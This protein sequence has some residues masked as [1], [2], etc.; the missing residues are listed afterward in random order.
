VSGNNEL[1]ALDF[2]CVKVLPREFYNPYFELTKMEN[3]K[4]PKKLLPLL[5]ELEMVLEED[6]IADKKL[7]TDT[8]KDIL[9]ILNQPFQFDV[10]DFSQPEFF[11]DL[12]KL[13]STLKDDKRIRKL[14]GNRGSK[15]FLYVN[16]T[17]F[18]LLG[19]MNSLKAGPIKVMNYKKYEL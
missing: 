13:G 5:D 7:L 14:N 11:N 18:G 8:F 19:L 16:R 1:I 15:H 3:I 9:S 12:L 10:F 17:L 6:S 4:N 2:G